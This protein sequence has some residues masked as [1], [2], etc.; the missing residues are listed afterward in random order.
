[1]D[2]FDDKPMLHKHAGKE[3][4]ASMK[5]TQRLTGMTSGQSAYPVCRL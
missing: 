2:L 3:I 5:G 1:M 4:P